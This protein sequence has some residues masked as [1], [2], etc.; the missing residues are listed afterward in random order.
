[1]E[2]RIVDERLREFVDE[3]GVDERFV[4]LDIKD[5]GGLRDGLDCLGEAVG[6]GRVIRRGHHG[7][8]SE[9]CHCRGDAFVIGGDEDFRK[10][11]RGLATLPYV[12]DQRFPGDEMQGLSG[13][14]CGAPARGKE[15]DD[16]M[17]WGCF[18]HAME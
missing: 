15:A 18:G 12:L 5:V 10:H 3:G 16:V 2:G 7:L 1:M 4:A 8:A 17:L 6:A 9:S 11:L 13:E 14:A